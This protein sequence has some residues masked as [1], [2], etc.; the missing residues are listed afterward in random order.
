MGVGGDLVGNERVAAC[1]S[2]PYIKTLKL[3]KIYFQKSYA[4]TGRRILPQTQ[5]NNNIHI[6]RT[7]KIRHKDPKSM[8]QVPAAQSPKKTHKKN[9]VKITN[10][11]IVAHLVKNV[12]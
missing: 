11:Q 9:E 1:K 7:D 2:Y 6:P 8:A 4:N 3:I 12:C 5:H 10:C